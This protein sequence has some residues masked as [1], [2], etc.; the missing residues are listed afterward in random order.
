MIII[1]NNNIFNVD[2]T[3]E[4]IINFKNINN[5]SSNLYYKN[6]K[7]DDNKSFSFYNIKE[8]DLLE[9]KINVIKRD[10]SI[11]EYDKQ[12]IENVL[13]LA[14]KN[15][16]TECDKFDEIN[17]FIIN[18]INELNTNLI[19]IEN[20]QDII[21][22]TLMIYSYYNTAKHYIS[23]RNDRSKKRKYN[24]YVSKIKDDVET[25]WGML[26]Y[27]TYKRTYAR[28]I[29]DDD[30]NET[31][32]EFRDSIL[33]VLDACQNQL[34]CNF[35]NNELKKAYYY[36]KSLKCSVAGRFLW[37]LGTETVNK[38]G[39]MSLQNCAFVAVD[40]PIRPFTWIFDVL[41]LGT[42]VGFS[43]QKE[44]ISKL[45]PVL[46]I[47]INI[48]RL[49]T[50]DADFIVPDSREGW[51]SLLEKI[52]ESFFYKGKSFT[53]STILIRSAGTK[54]K[55]FGGVASGPE[56]LVKGLKNIIDI[57]KSKRGKQLSSIDVLDIINIIAMIVVAGNVRRCIPKESKVFTKKGLVNIEDIITGDEA[58]TTDGYRKI[59]NYFNQ[60]KQKIVKIKTENGYFRCTKNHR[61]AVYVNNNN[62]VWK[63]AE[64]LKPDDLLI[65]NKDYIIGSDIKLPP[66]NNSNR[67]DRI[68]IPEFTKDIA[69]L[70][71]Y[72]IGNG[73]ID[74]TTTIKK[75]KI[76][77]YNEENFN[78][79]KEILV[80]F[81]ENIRTITDIDKINNNYF[82]E[83]V[84]LN[85][86]NYFN[87]NVKTNDI[88]YFINETTYE[89]RI[90][91]IRGVLN[92]KYCSIKTPYYSITTD[93]NNSKWLRSFQTLCYSCG[94]ESKYIETKS[95]YKLIIDNINSINIIN[96]KTIE[97]DNYEY[98]TSK[99]ISITNEENEVET[100]DIEVEDKHEFFCDGYL[101][102]NSALICLG[103]CDDTEY[104]NAKNWGNGNIPNWRSMSNNSVVCNDINDLSE[105]FWKLYNG[106]SEPYG[107][108]NIEL[109]R[110]IGR[111]KDGNKYPD[112]EVQGYNPCFS[113]ETLIATADGRGAVSIKKLAEEGNDIPVYSVNQE[114]MV[115]IKWGRNPRITGEN[116]KMV[117][118]I[119]DDD[120]YIKTTLNHKFRLID[121][122]I[123]EAKDLKPKMSLT[124]LNKYCAKVKN[125]DNTNYIRVN[126]NTKDMS[127]NQY[128]EHRL[129]AK[130][131]NPKKFNNIYN[132]EI[133]NGLIKGNVVVHHKDY[134]GLNNNPDNL[135][136]MTFE[137]H[138]KFHG[139]HDQSGENNGMY[140]KK[141]SK[142]TKKLI[143]DKVKERCE[144]PNYREKLSLGQKKMLE[145]N[146][147]LKEKLINKLKNVQ[148]D[149]YLK[150]CEEMIKKTD[151]ETLFVDGI[152]NVKKNCENCKNEFIIPFVK[153]EI[154]YCSVNCCNTSKKVIETRKNIRNIGL[155][156]KQKQNLHNQI[157]SYK[158][159]QEKLNRDPLKKEWEEECRNKGI[160]YRIR[161][162]SDK[163]CNE[164]TL[165]SY[166]ELKDKS[167][168]YNNEFKSNDNNEYTN[169]YQELKNK[170]N[171]NNEK[172]IIE[173]QKIT[174][175]NQIMI[176]KDLQEK[177]NRDPLK[178]EWKN[179]C[180][181]RKISNSFYKS[182]NEY[183]LKSYQELKNKAID[184][185]H[186]VKSI[187]FLEETETVYNIT[188]EDNHTIGIFTTYKNFIGNG[189]FT[190]QC[191]EIS[192]PSNSTCNLS[193]IF[194][195][196]IK[197]YE[198]LKELTTILY[199]ICKQSLT[200]KC[201]HKESDY[202][203]H[204]QYRI[205]VGIT[206][207]MM[208][209]DEQK[210]WLDPLYN[211]LREYDIEYSKTHNLPTSIK[212]TTVKPSGTLSLLAGVTPG[213]HP[214]IYK[215]FIRRIR[216]SVMNKTLLDLCK[217][218][219]YKIEYQR[220]FD[221][222][223]DK[224]TKII[225][226]PCKYPDGTIIAKDLTAIDQLNVMKELQY[227]WSDNAVSITVYYK[228]DEL[229]D[230]KKWLKE[231]YKDNI[232]SVSFLLLNE[233]GFLQAPYEEITKEKYDELIAN[234]KPITSGDIRQ[235]T[236]LESD[237]VGNSCPVK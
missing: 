103:D 164:Y 209:S 26:G 146:P 231:N 62:Y 148:H 44:Y 94:F 130:F 53:Y 68:N 193:E 143:A 207:Y 83:L 169:S 33:R 50:K 1:L 174:L 79:V 163:N 158:D 100:Y 49:D 211:F 27:I 40:S 190:F 192:L 180:K 58:L 28:K 87:D 205:G 161:Q 2:N 98:A 118:V 91:Y 114:G 63:M 222:T 25:P 136:I 173:K 52:L 59:T 215:Y 119:L 142:E 14:F 73:Y 95:G 197:S 109:S 60:G 107:L 188:V 55:G 125:D 54:I 42:G 13:K 86:L 48:S 37:Q 157:I 152:L 233:H 20:I 41:M 214:G 106:N 171:D 65:T 219:G 112:P 69:W 47:D 200:L 88:M 121:G 237:C 150:W 149:N 56:D 166:Q 18:E 210:S 72:F 139:E 147:E 84:S 113:G 75:L 191:G 155:A 159:L 221:G 17:N 10:N 16:N 134:N 7:L 223:D 202:I 151:L 45:P 144:D 178:E 32:E 181:N 34:N 160:P 201:H 117:K 22:K 74:N 127:K 182:N 177:L 218:N 120:T 154:C 226:F 135:E 196:N 206:G 156:E 39:I 195:P 96:D 78:K 236:D 19:N 93:N 234:V 101:T 105:E 168:N 36:L 194:L 90:E 185:N 217:K 124:R 115:E 122:T 138:S 38:L 216:I 123:I 165:K 199:R 70:F 167:L 172:T 228:L 208:C 97:C 71:G 235:E 162:D 203:I 230:I 12:K 66:C 57:L 227:I 140:G 145:D 224:N 176:Y 80:K 220:N 110:K 175:H 82:I 229:E 131:F 61:M 24:S 29:S 133:K 189:I 153:R 9:T 30:E 232:K 81:G 204:K 43:V 108:I 184:Y 46:D 129:I 85:L 179:E 5:I 141:Q 102:H 67:R 170:T 8:N 186:R 126:T 35:S 89:N 137:E 51:V 225:E 11:E 15:S 183:S 3:D 104:L 198:E 132:D 111:I 77:C 116:Q 76:C 64:E 187:E 21:E 128:Y 6:I 99:I 212:L 92:S 23:Y 213:A 4:V 31:T